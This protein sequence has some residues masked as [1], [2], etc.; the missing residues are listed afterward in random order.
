MGYPV[1]FLNL[2]EKKNPNISLDA[3]HCNLQLFSLILLEDILPQ[4]KN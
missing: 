3:L 1:I 4:N 2:K